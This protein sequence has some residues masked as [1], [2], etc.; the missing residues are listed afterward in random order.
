MNKYQKLADQWIGENDII[1]A[2][3]VDSFAKYLDEIEAK[4]VITNQC[5]HGVGETCIKCFPEDYRVPHPPK[6]EHSWGFKILTQKMGCEK[7]GVVLESTLKPQ[8][9]KEP[10]ELLKVEPSVEGGK[11]YLKGVDL[12]TVC[13][14]VNLL[15]KAHNENLK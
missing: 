6:C 5:A 8:S 1:P 15:I 10:I 4:V 13:R 11:W 2:K 3:Y 12:E 14:R 9:S 7:C